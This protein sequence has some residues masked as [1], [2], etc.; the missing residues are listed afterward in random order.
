MPKKPKSQSERA[1]QIAKYQQAKAASGKPK[2]NEDF[3]QAAHRV[4]DEVA[5][6]SESLPKS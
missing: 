2:R 4:F 1:R 6:R 3:N 5:R